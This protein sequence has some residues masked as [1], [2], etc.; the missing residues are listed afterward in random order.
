MDHLLHRTANESTYYAQPLPISLL[1]TTANCYFS[2]Q[3]FWHSRLSKKKMPLK[4]R[5]RIFNVS[6]AAR[7]HDLRLPQLK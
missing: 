1:C 3:L 6:F 2:G 7:D 4:K 5:R